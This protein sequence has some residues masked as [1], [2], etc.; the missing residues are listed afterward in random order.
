[1]TAPLAVRDDANIIISSDTLRLKRH[2][3]SSGG[4]RRVDFRVFGSFASS[5]IIGMI[6]RFCPK[7]GQTGRRS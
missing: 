7:L 5:Y 3:G 6:M 4:G 2:L 1:M